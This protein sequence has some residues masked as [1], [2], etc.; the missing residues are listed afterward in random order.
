MKK[1]DSSRL[2]ETTDTQPTNPHDVP[3]D[4]YT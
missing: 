1:G 3:I 2:K 4:T